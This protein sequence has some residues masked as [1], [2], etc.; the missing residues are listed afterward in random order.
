MI[1]RTS[2][3][4]TYRNINNSLNLLS[5]RIAQLSNKV[6]SEKS[7]NKPSDNPSGAAQVLKTRS[8][9]AE[10]AQNTENVNYSNTWLTNTGNA[11]SSI[12]S[13]LDEIY[14]KAEQ[15]A[16]DTYT[17]EQRA[18]IATEIDA[19]FQSVIQFADA[20]FGDN[21]L[22]SGSQ[23]NVRPFSLEQNAQTVQ[24]GCDNSDLFTG[25]VENYLNTTYAAR[26][27]LPAQSQDFLVEIVRA[28][29]ID[30]GLY[31][32][33]G[34]LAV[35]KINGS[36]S[37]GDYTLTIDSDSQSNNSTKVR[38][39]PG[40]ENLSNTGVPQS[41][42]FISYNYTSSSPIT[43][44]YTYGSASTSTWAQYSASTS[45]MTVY[46]Q[47]D[48]NDP[49]K[50]SAAVTAMS[51][52]G[53][54]NYA[55][56]NYGPP[57]LP[58][59]ATVWMGG[60]GHVDLEPPDG[61]ARNTVIN[62]NNKTFAENNGDEITVYLER[63]ADGQIVATAQD[64]ADALNNH[65]TIGA[66]VTASLTGD[67][68]N[69]TVNAQNT[70]MSMTP[71][72]P[73]T[74]AF[75]ETAISGTHNDLVY[76]VKN[77]AGAPK[78]EAGNAYSVIYQWA[79]PP[80]VGAETTA[81]F[82]SATSAII[83]TLGTSGALFTQEYARLI[84]DPTSPGYGNPTQAMYLARVK[85]NTA[86]ANSVMSAVTA[87]S[88]S[89]N[90]HIGVKLADGNS[91]TG[92]VVP[93]GSFQLA[94][95]YDQ[96]ALFR[97]SQDGGKTWGPPTAF[98]PSEF[99]AGGLFYNS[100]LGHASLTTSLPGSANDLVFTANYMGTWGD[101]VRIEY[102]KPQGPY[103]TSASVT[104]GPQSWNICVNL[105]TDSMGNVTTTADEVM[106]LINNHPEA[107][108]LVTVSLA[109]YHEGGGGRVAVMACTSLKTE[110]PYE[111]DGKTKITPLGHATASVTFPYEAPAQS[112]PDLIYQALEHGKI[113][114]NIGIRYTMSADTTLYGPDALY[115]D[116]VS[117]TYETD[118]QNRQ[119][120]VVHLATTDL[121]S[122][123]DK[124]TE[125]EA[126]DQF[127]EL[128]P[129]YS[130][131]ETRAVVSTAGQVLEAIVAK[132]LAE[133]DQALV[134]ASM[135]Y[136]DEGWDSTAK[137]GPTSGTVW[138]SGGDDSLKA[139]D[140]GVGL[141]FISD[142]SALQVG[143]VYEVKVG[144]YNGDSNNLDIDSMSGYRTTTNVTGDALLGANGDS[145]N[146][147][148]TISRLSWGLTHDD[149]EL[150]A[151]ELPKLKAALEKV[152]TMETNI[153]T[154]LI[155]NQFVLNNLETNKYSAETILSETEDA[156]FT[157]LITDL[158]N[159]QLVYEAVLGV[160][161]LT[162]KLT[163]LNY[164]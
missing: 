88:D 68:A 145:D 24:S 152:T 74:L 35:M 77:E 85:A 146:I 75:V 97:V 18:I 144:W 102:Q 106:A 73:Y 27:D 56:S 60:G 129:V 70:F 79:E 141:K 83:V 137:V 16:T 150:I 151:K 62:F 47:T 127:R 6:A 57:A 100:Q 115:Q 82:D 109:N 36:N 161:G 9:I 149:S 122:C 116:T 12:K 143:D 124:D 110:E 108:Q 49:P 105:G 111:I 33:Q 133:P 156:D 139:S 118:D 3:R 148:D 69:G 157:T 30:S 87:L 155:R 126:Y 41:D 31:A 15:G 61:I 66:K 65:P 103:P 11:V 91:G 162:T 80:T 37:L 113:G 147:L 153:G 78:G 136:K 121:P 84:N 51:I 39:V 163:L 1:Y 158:K 134:W 20:K 131:S 44:V 95:G 28:G 25:L 14:S 128:W 29:G 117:I 42:T 132:N 45:T 64:V 43:V 76:Y 10:I 34:E 142:G 112:S 90:L 19:L 32:E 93:S 5:Y 2:Q 98:S 40:P 94:N 104:L 48:G 154:K 119:I 58:L 38:L 130:C 26:P 125:R 67:G 21:Y 54:V 7:I 92:K 107:G 17:K 114:D 140:Y 50:S 4:G 71:T 22:F 52:A 46:L 135:D 8:V 63:S 164:L 160:T 99:E 86:D 123:P 81:E 89:A 23:V 101:D 72:D 96:V 55:A 159:S 13:T 138:L 59:T 120:V 53:A